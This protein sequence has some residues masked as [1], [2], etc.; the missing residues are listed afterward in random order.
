[1]IGKH[2]AGHSTTEV[3][4]MKTVLTAI[5]CYGEKAKTTDVLQWIEVVEFFLDLDKVHCSQ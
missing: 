4:L 5:P 2:K 3:P 1:M